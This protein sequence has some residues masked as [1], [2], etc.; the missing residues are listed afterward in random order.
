LL[1]NGAVEQ[2]AV[3]TDVKGAK[4]L[5]VQNNVG[6]VNIDNPFLPFGSMPA[7][8]NY[9]LIGNNEVFQK[10]L[11]D[12]KI[13]IEWF[14]VPK[15]NRGFSEYYAEYGTGV[16]NTSF[17]AKVSVLDGGRWKPEENEEK[18]TI[19]LFRTL[20]KE[21]EIEPEEKS[22]VSEKLP[23]QNLDIEKIRKEPNYSEIP[24]NLIYSNLTKRGF[25][26]LELTSPSEAFG[27]A[28]YPNILSEVTLNNAKTGVLKGTKKKPLPSPPITPTIK[29]ITLDYK[30]SAVISV[31]DNHSTEPELIEKQGQ[32]FHIHAFGKEKVYPNKSVNTVN[33]LPGYDLQY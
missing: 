32:L 9:L 1:K 8:G 7:V 12:L 24:N 16:D 29:S 20:G 25:I 21:N 3:K 26:K 5:V 28:V 23:L 30:S 27:H 2:I 13:N 14:E 31:K 11:D 18:Q 33:L 17:E 19:K 6:P 10:H 22:V 4:D 15:T